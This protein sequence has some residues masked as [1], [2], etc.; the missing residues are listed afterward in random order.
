M[1]ILSYR[2][3]GEP[4]Q[5]EPNYIAARAFTFLQRLTRVKLLTLLHFDI[6]I[7]IAFSSTYLKNRIARR[8]VVTTAK[9]SPQ[10]ARIRRRKVV[11]TILSSSV[12]MQY[13]TRALMNGVRDEMT[14]TAKRDD[15]ESFWCIVPDRDRIS[16]LPEEPRVFRFEGAKAYELGPNSTVLQEYDAYLTI[17]TEV[18]ARRQ[19]AGFLYVWKTIKP[20][21]GDS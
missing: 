9:G 18:S 14:L 13:I 6:T 11:Y 17:N 7:K 21:K 3:G 15:V 10:G 1:T 2:P 5:P 19:P 16:Q 20:P 8:D 4:Y 12:G